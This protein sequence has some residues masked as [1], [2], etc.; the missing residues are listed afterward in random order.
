LELLA[1]V[2]ISK[3]KSDSEGMKMIIE[4]PNGN[5]THVSL[6]A[7]RIE[8]AAG[9]AKEVIVPKP[10]LDTTPH[11]AVILHHN[12]SGIGGKT[13]AIQL[14]VGPAVHLYIGDPKFTN[15]R[16]QWKFKPSGARYWQS[17][18]GRYLAFGREVPEEIASEYKRQWKKH[19]KYRGPYDNVGGPIAKTSAE[20]KAERRAEEILEQ[21]R[22]ASRVAMTEKEILAE[23]SSFNK[24]LGFEAAPDSNAAA[25]AEIKRKSAAAS[26]IVITDD[27]LAAMNEWKG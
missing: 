7:G 8:I 13:L 2:R 25:V 21:S 1:G 23:L 17:G 11:W 18:E 27:Q 6:E 26:R 14:R 5:R 4:F 12:S 10:Q 20:I 9:R 3:S 16:G 22:E 15:A 24:A 19:E